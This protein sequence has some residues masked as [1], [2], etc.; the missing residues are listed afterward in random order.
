MKEDIA[1]L[2]DLKATIY[3]FSVSWPRIFPNCNGQVN[4]AGL[5]YYSDLIDEVIKNGATPLLTIFHWYQSWNSEEIVQD[6]TNYADLLFQTFGDR[7]T[8]YLT[9][10]LDSGDPWIWPPGMMLSEQAKYDCAH[11]VN[12]AHASI[13]QMAR[14]KY[15]SKNFK[16]GIP[17]II[18][19]GVP[20]DPNSAADVQLAQST[21]V[22][23]S[24]WHWGPMVFGDYPAYLR[25][26]PGGALY[27][28]FNG[29]LLPQ[30]TDAQ[31]QQIKGTIDFLGINY[32]SATYRSASGQSG[33]TLVESG[34]SWQH[35]YPN[36]IR[37][38]SKMLSSY[39]GGL[40]VI[41]TECGTAVPNEKTM[42]TAQRVQDDFRQSFFEGVVAALSDAVLID[43]TPI[44]AF[45]AWSLLDNLEWL[46]FD[47]VWG[48]VSVDQQGGTL[49]RSVKNSAKY[50]SSYFSNS[51]SPFTLPAP[52]AGTVPATTSTPTTSTGG[53]AADKSGEEKTVV[54]ALLTSL[55]GF[56]AI[57]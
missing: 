3:R 46:T 14:K 23:Q 17:L 24:D 1:I 45:I 52:S 38:I 16:F 39:Y 43:K 7:V 13:V 54:S 51:Q 35:L 25:T 53:G 6:I 44:K 32:Y 47:Q 34:A 26:L 12:L 37:E 20:V 29:A 27:N 30:F 49:T 22:A 57:L 31:K 2:G 11:H 56:L 21:T 5:Q 55:L 18:E 10:N 41:I 19:L 28:Y 40:E 4:Q 8:H 9:V 36:G 50:L 15:A 48:L 33:P 42:T